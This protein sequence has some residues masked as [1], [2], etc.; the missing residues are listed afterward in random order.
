MSSSWYCGEFAVRHLHAME[1]TILIHTSNPLHVALLALLLKLS[2]VDDQEAHG[3]AAVVGALGDAE[4]EEEEEE[5]D[6]ASAEVEEDDSPV[7]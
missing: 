5:E 7:D 6:D 4:L 1:K 3:G 2:A